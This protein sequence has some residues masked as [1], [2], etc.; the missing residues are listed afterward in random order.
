MT[1][2]RAT[3]LVVDD[4]RNFRNTLCEL[5]QSEGYEVRNAENGRAALS[6]LQ[7]TEV[8]V[9]L[10]DWRMPEMGGEQVLKTLASEDRLGSMPV[11]IMTAY[12]TGPNALQA[13]QLG[14]YDF[15]SKPLDMQQLLSTVKRAVQQVALQRELDTLRKSRFAAES[16]GILPDED[17]ASPR[18]VGSAPAWIDV[19]KSIGKVARTDVGVLILGESGT[20]KEMVA[21][22]IH[23]NSSR[24]RKPFTIIN[25]AA[26][27]ADLLESELFGHE[28]GSFTSAVAQKIGKFEAANGGTVFLDEIGELPLALQPKLLRI[29]QERTFERVGSTVPLRADVRILAATN[30]SLELEVEAKAFRA[31]LFYRLNAYSLRLPALRER[32]TDILPLAEYFLVRF[33][34]RHGIPAQ[35]LTPEAATALQ[36]YTFPGNVRELEHL[37]ERVAIQAAGRSITAEE[38]TRNLSR[39][40]LPPQQITLEALLQLPFHQATSTLEKALIE[41]ALAEARQNKSEAARRLGM[42]RRLLYEKLRQYGIEE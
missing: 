32:K 41:H 22:T 38:V 35:E 11:L 29:L 19:F 25:C 28:R 40:E 1:R 33:A 26:L 14:A 21:R 10:C 2:S 42:H 5:L 18:L 30:R 13:M 15:V 37:V 34:R 17:S 36:Q 9:T 39:A 6:L 16:I 23:E 31:D 24:S 12:G 8:D 4:D 27:P 7:T 3:L 20:G